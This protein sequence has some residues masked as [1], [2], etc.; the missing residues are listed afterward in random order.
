MISFGCIYLGENF[1]LLAYFFIF[2]FC[3]SVC[4]VKCNENVL[5]RNIDFKPKVKWK[6]MSSK[7]E[8]LHCIGNSKYFRNMLFYYYYFPALLWL[9]YL[10]HARFLCCTYHFVKNGMLV[11]ALYFSQ[12]L[13]QKVFFLDRSWINLTLQA[14]NFLL[15]KLISLYWIK[16]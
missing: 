13:F 8:S 11:V 7:R 15:K 16:A 10:T 2:F 9:L 12:L 1:L 4:E 3:M 6:K 5:S 14:N